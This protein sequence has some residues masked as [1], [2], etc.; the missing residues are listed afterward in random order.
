[1][2]KIINSSILI[3]LIQLLLISS[4]YADSI[5]LPEDSTGIII[6]TTTDSSIFKA[7]N[8]DSINPG[9]YATLMAIYTILDQNNIKL[10]DSIIVGD[11]IINI[12]E[13]NLIGLTENQS[14][15]YQE[16]IT[17][18]LLNSSSDALKVLAVN[19][20]KKLLNDKT[21]SNESALN[22]FSEE[23]NKVAEE[24]GMEN[25]NFST[26]FWDSSSNQSTNYS[27]LSILINNSLNNEDI[28]RILSNSDFSFTKQ[29]SKSSKTKSTSNSTNESTEEKEEITFTVENNN[30]LKN[31][32][33]VTFLDN[34][35]GSIS[36]ITSDLK[37]NA[38][39]VG[40]INNVNAENKLEYLEDLI[41]KIENS[42]EFIDLNANDFLINSKITNAS[43]SSNKELEIVGAEDLKLYLP[44]SEVKNLEGNIY[45]DEN[46][47]VDNGEGLLLIN[48][49]SPSTS[50][51]NLEIAYNN[52]I[53]SLNLVSANKYTI[54]NWQ[55]S[56][57]KIFFI[58]LPIIIILLI[59]WRL[60]YVHNRRK[61]LRR[62]R[63]RRRALQRRRLQ[64]QRIKSTRV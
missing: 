44:K 8:E 15:T 53:I 63:A 4:V 3:L 55:D 12:S 21:A 29:E 62:K 35:T 30:S 45:W 19:T 11:E 47:I 43:F 64:Q 39:I 5:E 28:I 20:G 32:D 57:I 31:N 40:I 27:D 51:G 41:Q 42:Y 46:Y 60:I 58:S 14:V 49:I 18:G 37:D 36:F 34:S 61:V 2:K 54:K 23:M 6:E 1:M 26:N 25:S 50:I 17:V 24:L 56:L 52:D 38:A 7:D 22:A 33:I 59:L 48:S 13:G 9:N 10:S 16:L